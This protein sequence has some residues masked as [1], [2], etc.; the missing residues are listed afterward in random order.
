MKETYEDIQKRQD[1]EMKNSLPP[2]K[3]QA[4]LDMQKEGMSKTL[5]EEEKGKAEKEKEIVKIHPDPD[6]CL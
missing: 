6:L 5:K 2:E 1:E 4:F 3:Y